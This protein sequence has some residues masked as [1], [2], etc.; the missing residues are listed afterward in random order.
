MIAAGL[1]REEAQDD[2][3]KQGF[4]GRVRVACVNSPSSVTISGDAVAIDEYLSVL[5]SE[6]AFA[7]LLKTDNKAYHSHHMSLL[8][9]VY[10]DLLCEA[11]IGN[12]SNRSGSERSTIEMISSVTGL[13]I[14]ESLTSSP[15]YWRA[16]LES[17]VL[18]SDAMQ[19]LLTGRQY[20]LIEV[21]PHSALELP[22]KQICQKLDSDSEHVYSSTLS[23]FKDSAVSLLKCIGDLYL[24][25]HGIA[26]ERVNITRSSLS[27]NAKKSRTHK[28]RVISNLPKYNWHYGALLW[29]ESRMSTEFRNRK[30]PRHD[31]LGSRIPGGPG[32]MGLWRNVL[33]IKDVPWLVD[34]KMGQSIVFPAT[35]YLAMAIEA[36]SQLHLIDSSEN[37]AITLRHVHLVSALHLGSQDSEVELFTQMA[38]KHMSNT[39]SSSVW[40]DFEITSYLDQKSTVH[41]RGMVG[42]DNIT[43]SPDYR[44]FLTGVD[45]GPQAVRTWYGQL[46]KE[47]LN[48]GPSFQSLEEIHNPRIQNSRQTVAKIRPLHGG[49]EDLERQ[50]EYILHPISMD[51][52]LQT[53]IISSA[54]GVIHELHGKVPV[55]IGYAR[56]STAQI[57]DSNELSTIQA[58][59][60]YTSFGA[61]K[62]DTELLDAQGRSLLQL[63]DVRV[64]TSPFQELS[65]Q[66]DINGDRCP[67]LRVLWKPDITTLSTQDANFTEYTDKISFMPEFVDTE[68]G[69]LAGALDLLAHKYPK[70]RILELG[71]AE[72]SITSKFLDLLGI[73]TPVK[74]FKSYTQGSISQE[75]ELVG[76]EISHLSQLDAE[77]SQASNIA[78]Q[79]KFDVVL[80]LSVSYDLT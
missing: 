69:R 46:A 39:S 2:I 41:V 20:H 71:D 40:W 3:L 10:E 66:D 76:R 23:R 65:G 64:Q 26:F 44:T 36:L 58:V 37:P 13:P 70:L 75:G 47:G 61:V 14:S 62:F 57:T 63:N 11:Q 1:S 73:R 6:G 74:R 68:S 38:L 28:G 24:H 12:R 8:G 50:S 16:N 19:T 67:M 60:E 51:A 31:L 43:Q 45:L 53:G 27:S 33:R 79:A 9:P 77:L 35:G 78:D 56:I 55:E 29:C 17:P 34:H 49:G 25:G 15:A 72:D 5:K 54:Q 52:L 42:F 32:G 80:L 4:E 48:F 7:R 30:H 21:G 22:I 18:F 59:S